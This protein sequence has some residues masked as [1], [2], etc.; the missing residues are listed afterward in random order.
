MTKSKNSSIIIVPYAND[1]NMRT[2][3]NIKQQNRLEV[4][5]KNCCVALI[6]TKRHNKDSDVALV[7]N[8]EIPIKYKTFLEENDIL[9]IKVPFS[10][11]RFPDDYKWGLAFYKLCALKHLVDNFNYEYLA[12]LDADV[13]V[14]ST[15]KSI[16]EEC[17]QN[18]LLYDINHGL[19]V[20]N[21]VKFLKDAKKFT[22]N[23]NIITHYGGEF[24]AASYKNA[25]EFVSECYC[26]YKKMLDE[27]FHTHFGD[28]FIV[29]IVANRLRNKIRN[30]GSY[31]FRFWTGSFRLISTAYKFNPIIII[32]T[33]DE[34][35]KGI[36]KIYNHLV[37][38][39]Q[40]PSSEKVYR[41]LHLKRKSIKTI[42]CEIINTFIKR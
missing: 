39:K 7:T 29:S 1:D 30:A 5:L 4:Y 36:I 34:K 27:K 20:E 35:D 6:S 18:I 24:F 14:Q 3:V 12:Y 13:Y 40:F 8:I 25:E 31:I 28:E 26:V 42:T 41:I 19:R 16:W 32:H 23:D 37:K 22:K 2:G 11:F 21:F 17:K 38:N 10:S 15:F 33:P 9:I